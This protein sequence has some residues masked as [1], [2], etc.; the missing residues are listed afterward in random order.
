MKK[1]FKIVL[2]SLILIALIGFA[3]RTYNVRFRPIKH[4]VFFADGSL[5][6][7][8]NFLNGKPYGDWTTYYLGGKKHTSYSL[9]NEGR[10]NDSLIKW[11]PSGEI[12]VKG[13]YENGR[14]AGCWVWLG[15]DGREIQ[16]ECFNANTEAAR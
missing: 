2:G 11:H 16:K 15:T 3:T 14:K 9:D 5:R 1:T 8:G 4:A 7:V 13:L 10:L 6:E 12:W